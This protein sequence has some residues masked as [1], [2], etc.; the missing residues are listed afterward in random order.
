MRRKTIFLILLSV[1]LSMTFLT[2][3]ELPN[4]NQALTRQFSLSDTRDAVWEA[5]F[6]DGGYSR[7]TDLVQCRNGDLVFAGH[8]NHTL[9]VEVSTNRYTL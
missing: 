2:V 1:I 4:N 9:G 5:V 6:I 8:T 3:H 7:G